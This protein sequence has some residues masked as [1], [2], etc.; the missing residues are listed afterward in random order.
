ML[1][2]SKRS[3]LPELLDAEGIP[4]LDLYRNYYE[5]EQINKL[6]SGYAPTLKGIQFFLEKHP[7]R[8]EPLRILDVGCGGGDTLRKIALW[9]QSKNV[10]VELYGVD[11]LDDAINYAKKQKSVQPINYKVA[12]FREFDVDQPFHL[13]ISA[14]FCH[15][16]DKE[17]LA[18]IL[19]SQLKMA[20]WGVI[21]NDLHR[22]P[23]AYWSI[24]W[25]TALYSKSYLVRHDAALSVLKAFKIG[26]WQR[27]LRDI[28]VDEYHIKWLWAFRYLITIETS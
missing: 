12:D 25:L 14:L 27:T 3:Y 7:T 20:K 17:N 8:H 19:M 6:L 13:V 4:A 9:A 22:H 16:L 18:S 26:D 23:I 10:D 28:G 21:V 15:H 11:L 2:F 24:K 5:I 1:D